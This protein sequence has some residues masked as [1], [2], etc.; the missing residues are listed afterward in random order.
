MA[1][2][3]WKNKLVPKESPTNILVGF[4]LVELP[5]DSSLFLQHAAAKYAFAGCLVRGVPG[6]RIYKKYNIPLYAASKYY[7][8]VPDQASQQTMRRCT[9]AATS[10]IRGHRGKDAYLLTCALKNES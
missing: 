8:R 6:S 10:L 5:K 1:T 3:C 4:V 7:F 2:A 9:L